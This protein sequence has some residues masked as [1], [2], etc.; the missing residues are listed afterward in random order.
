MKY[1]LLLLFATLS[2]ATSGCRKTINETKPLLNDSILIVNTI[3]NHM[4]LCKT[5]Y[6]DEGFFSDTIKQ[7][8]KYIIRSINKET[9]YSISHNMIFNSN[10]SKE[11]DIDYNLYEAYQGSELIIDNDIFRFNDIVLLLGD[12]TF[13]E[14]DKLPID[15]A[16]LEETDVGRIRY[17][18]D[19]TND[20]YIFIKCGLLGCNGR[21]CNSYYILAIKI[22]KEG[23]KDV[24]IIDYSYAYPLDFQN[25]PIFK[26]KEDK[27]INIVL[28][29]A[30]NDNIVKVNIN[31]YSMFNRNKE[32]NKDK[33]REL[34]E[35]TY[36]YQWGVDSPKIEI[37]KY[38]WY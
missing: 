7:N 16:K 10:F 21:Y 29:N 20:E 24:M 36:T 8:D 17:Y 4:D 19:E 12:N 13:N 38:N 6:Y 28:C 25:I 14:A 32:L 2:F 23:K 27:S 3:T 22:D 11:F 5:I 26:N 34:K 31:S 33:K 1:I 30:I 37:K 35:I 18:K 15:L 9:G